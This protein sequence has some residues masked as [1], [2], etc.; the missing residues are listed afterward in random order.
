MNLRPPIEKSAPRSRNRLLLL[1]RLRK[2]DLGLGQRSVDG[3]IRDAVVLDVKEP[4]V[5]G[6][7][8]N[9]CG[10]VFAGVWVA[11]VYVGE[12]DDGDFGGVAVPGRCVED[13][14]IDGAVGA[15]KLELV[16]A[17]GR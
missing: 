16:G 6:R 3:T 17:C 11:A 8:A 14:A 13:V 12:I 4:R 10:E 9:R 2:K 15:A 1:H 5:L 7:G